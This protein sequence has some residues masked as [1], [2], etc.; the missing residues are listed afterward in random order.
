MLHLVQFL[1]VYLII[2]FIF[3]YD[4]SIQTIQIGKASF[5]LV[6]QL[7][8]A[9]SYDQT[10]PAI[11]L[12]LA[13]RESYI[14]KLPQRFV[15]GLLGKPHRD[16]YR[17]LEFILTAENRV[18]D[19]IMHTLT[20]TTP[21]TEIFHAAGKQSVRQLCDRRVFK[22]PCIT[23]EQDAEIFARQIELIWNIRDRWHAQD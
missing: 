6:F 18:V 16:D 9:D 8:V 15:K 20:I 4:I 17:T 22:F 14:N 21:R 11:R 13:R 23:D 2:V 19:Q 12:I 7:A 5:D 1:N 10:C 3:T